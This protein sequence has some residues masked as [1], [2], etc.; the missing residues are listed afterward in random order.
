M[1][2]TLSFVTRFLSG[3]L[4]ALVFSACSSGGVGDDHP[5]IGTWQLD[6]QLVDIG[7]GS[8]TY[9]PVDSDRTLTFRSDGTVTANFNFCN[10]IDGGT[11]LRSG[12]WSLEEGTLQPDCRPDR[13]LP[14]SLD[15]SVLTLTPFCIEACGE[16]YRKV[17]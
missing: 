2:H 15:D 14:L 13:P 6:E 7:D 5:L 8:G 1:T 9:Q 12:S 3:L 17:E 10:P 4:F 11:Q 16:R